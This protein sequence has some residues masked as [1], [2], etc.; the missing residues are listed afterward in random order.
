MEEDGPRIFS[1]AES[2]GQMGFSWKREYP[3]KEP[4]G[5][6]DETASGPNPTLRL[7]SLITKYVHIIII[8]YRL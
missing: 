4:L 1:R 6:G 8:V 5:S 7:F 3:N 2:W